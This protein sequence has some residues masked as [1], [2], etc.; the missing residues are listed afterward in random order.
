M[1]TITPLFKNDY[2]ILH[3]LSEFHTFADG[4]IIIYD[5]Y[6]EAKNDCSKFEKSKVVSCTKL[7]RKNRKILRRNIEKF[8]VPF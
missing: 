3:S 7:S 5:T 4:E 6:V 8:E 2:V 1:H